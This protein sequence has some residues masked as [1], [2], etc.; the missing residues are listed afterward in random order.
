MVSRVVAAC[1]IVLFGLS[2][3]AEEIYYYVDENGIVHFANSQLNSKYRLW[4]RYGPK[5]K[6][7]SSHDIL[8][9]SLICAAA[10]RA[11]VEPA[12]MVALV[13]AESN[14]NRFA[15]SNKDAKGLC[16]LTDEIAKAYGV[17]DPFDPAQNLKAGAEHLADLL[18]RFKSLELALAAYNAGSGAVVR[19]KGIPPYEQTR[20][21]VEKVTGLY[22]H[23]KALLGS[24]TSSS[25]K[26]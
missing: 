12:L 24:A 25:L 19:H 2:A 18:D 15:V 1:L 7:N 11:G 10:E 6:Y 21:F 23:Y 26:K 20:N 5:P 8:Y 16:Q 14:F 17:D 9:R 3:F 22:R 4:K 13:E